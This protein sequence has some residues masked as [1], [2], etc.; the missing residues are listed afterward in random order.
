MFIYF[1][2]APNAISFPTLSS[3]AWWGRHHLGCVLVQ[4]RSDLVAL[5]LKS[6]HVLKFAKRHHMLV[7]LLNSK[8]LVSARDCM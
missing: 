2:L 8:E 3:S 6:Y 5:C 1:L 7:W 4:V